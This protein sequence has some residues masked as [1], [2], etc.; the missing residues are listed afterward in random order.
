MSPVISL[1]SSSIKGH[2]TSNRMPLQAPHYTIRAKGTPQRRSGHPRLLLSNLAETSHFATLQLRHLATN[3]AARQPPS[4]MFH[5][6]HHTLA[7]TSLSIARNDE[8][9]TKRA[10]NETDPIERTSF[11]ATPTKANIPDFHVPKERGVQA[12]GFLNTSM[13]IVIRAKR[14]RQARPVCMPCMHPVHRTQ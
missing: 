8:T 5:T 1:Q 6:D 7:P 12:S 3:K 11:L 4:T 14:R 9:S 2:S 13:S 10:R